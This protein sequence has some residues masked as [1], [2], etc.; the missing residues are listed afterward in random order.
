[1]LGCLDR[2]TRGTYR[3]DGRDVGSLS[4]DELSEVRS[5]RI[6]FV[7]QSFHLVGRLS[8]AENVALP[9]LLAGVP[10]DERER[11]VAA[12]LESVGLAGRA[13]HR[14]NELSGGESQRV[15][16]ARATVMQPRL[17]LADEPTGNLDSAAGGSIMDLLEQMNRDGLTLVV[18]THD[19]N[20]GR[21]AQRVLVLRDG[22]IVQRVAG[23]ELAPELLLA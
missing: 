1:V 10:L 13:R 6:G 23:R 17:L 14:P 18:V 19:L 20:I 4:D 8:A 7:F 22:E 15:A 16:I 3:L 2:S 21:R 9:M 5:H 11:R 12:A